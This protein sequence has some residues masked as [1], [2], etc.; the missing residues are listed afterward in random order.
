[1]A[2]GNS[3]EN[4]IWQIIYNYRFLF[5]LS[6]F[7]NLSEQEQ[8]TVMGDGAGGVAGGVL[9]SGSTLGILGGAAAGGFVGH[10]LTDDEDKQ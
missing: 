4:Y 2:R 10:I 3:N 8:N 7:A 9:T 1:M 6:G 5:R